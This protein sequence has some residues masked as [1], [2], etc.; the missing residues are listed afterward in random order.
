MRKTEFFWPEFHC[1][2]GFSDHHTIKELLKTHRHQQKGCLSC[3]INKQEKNGSWIFGIYAECV[4]NRPMCTHSIV[5]GSPIGGL[6]QH[7]V[8]CC[9]DFLH[10]LWGKGCTSLPHVNVLSSDSHYTLMMAWPPLAAH[11]AFHP[12]ALASNESQHGSPRLHGKV[13]TTHVQRG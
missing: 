2:K 13:T 4:L 7:F 3:A 6:H 11:T 9:S 1:N 8:A 10:M 5:D 12:P